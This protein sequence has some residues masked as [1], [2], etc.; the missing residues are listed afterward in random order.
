MDE[1]FSFFVRVKQM[2]LTKLF[3]TKKQ[4]INKILFPNNDFNFEF[5]TEES[6]DGMYKVALAYYFKNKYKIT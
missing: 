3:C 1:I 2:I 5:E 4:I 6:I